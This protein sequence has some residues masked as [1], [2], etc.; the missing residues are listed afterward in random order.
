MNEMNLETA[1]ALTRLI[2]VLVQL[3][4]WAGAALVVSICFR[5]MGETP[6][7]LLCALAELLRGRPNKP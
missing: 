6:S 1:Q 5:L 4:P 7:R 3:A 2:D